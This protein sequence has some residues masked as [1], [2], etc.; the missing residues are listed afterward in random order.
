MTHLNFPDHSLAERVADGI[1]HAVGITAAIAG[2]IVLLVF[3]VP[4]G[5][6]LSIA[7]LSVYGIALI[8]LFSVS[9]AYH[10]TP[11]S[12]AKAVLGRFDQ[13]CIYL[14]IA[15]TYT[16]FMLVKLAAWPGA[17]LLVFVWSVATFG[18]ANKLLF[19]EQLKRTTYVLYLAL[20]WCV[21]IVLAPLLAVLT[22][23]SLALLALG[24]VLYTVGVVFHLWPGLRFRNAI[25][26]CFV[27]AGAACHYLAIMD[28]V[29]LT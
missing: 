13:A 4:A 22:T 21:V 2:V 23:L 12:A 27:L 24:G 3:A 8:T 19:P 28:S 16:P 6:P 7:S 5:E 11:A 20:G 15:S 29:A 26:H 17:G 14:K 10:L 25:W 1:V 9:A 18:I